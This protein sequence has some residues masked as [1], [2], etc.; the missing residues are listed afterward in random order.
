MLGQWSRS[1]VTW[2]RPAL[3]S[4]HVQCTAS[5]TRVARTRVEQRRR[6]KR[7]MENRCV[8]LLNCAD[9]AVP[10]L[11]CLVPG[12]GTCNGLMGCDAPRH[13]PVTGSV[14]PGSSMER[15]HV[16]LAVTRVPTPSSRTI[17]PRARCVQGHQHGHHSPTI[18]KG[19]E[20]TS[21]APLT[22]QWPCC[23]SCLPFL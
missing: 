1:Q 6:G 10:R 5:A 13:L 21:S 2:K 9:A 23:S 7:I 14:S 3:P 17:N 15:R 8:P 11:V 19:S 18:I 22:P 12:E 20:V 16:P 4:D